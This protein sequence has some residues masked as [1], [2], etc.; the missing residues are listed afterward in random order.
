MSHTADFLLELGCEELPAR[1]VQE[2]ARML[3]D[4]LAGE[5]EKAGLDFDPGASRRLA[6]PRRLTVFF[7]GLADRQ[8]DRQLDRK[9][10]AVSAAFDTDG[11]P[12]RAAEGFA[13][14]VGLPV[15][16]LERLKNEQG[17]WLFARIDEPGKPL[18]DLLPEMLE[19]IIKTM[20][21]ARS[22][23]WGNRSERFLRPVRWLV[24]L[25]GDHVL[26]LETM[27]LTATAETRGHRVHAPGP[28][29]LKSAGDYE[30][31]LEQ[32]YVIADPARR[33]QRIAEQV[34]AAA[35]QAGLA[36][37]PDADLLSEVSNLVEWPRPVL[38]EFDA[39]FLTVPPEALIASMQQHQKTFP[40]FD[41]QGNLANRFVAIANIEST[42]P[43]AMRA[44]FERVIRPRLSDAKFFWDQDRRTP[45]AD[46]GSRLADVRFQEKMGSVG[47]KVQRV[48]SLSEAMA[49]FLNPSLSDTI[50][51]A[52]HLSKCDLLTEMVGEF[53]E[54][55][56]TMGKYYALESGEDEA[57][58]TAI[59]S[60]YRPRFA[61]DDLPDDE[62]KIG[63]ILALADRADTLVGIFA[64]GRKPKGGKDPFALRRAALGVVR[65]LVEKRFELT[66]DDLLHF[67]SKQLSSELA[68]NDATL[69]A[70]RTFILD[71]LRSYAQSQNIDTNT[72]YAVNAVFDPEF[73][74]LADFM[75]R[76]HAVQAFADNPEVASLI[77]ANKRIKNILEQAG[78]ATFNPGDEDAVQDPA[79]KQLLTGLNNADHETSP[80]PNWSEQ[81]YRKALNTLAVLRDPVDTFFD[82]VMVMVDDEDL[83]HAR[84]ALLTRLREVFTRI[85]DVA[86]LGR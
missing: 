4:G 21:G 49:E 68:V 58:A 37:H 8:P 22:M 27:G 42:D 30:T 38:G 41:D 26:P 36:A 76:A 11:N 15:E 29:R 80:G 83:R 74:T 56:G 25:H 34:Q 75:D 23:K 59:E 57:V 53:P 52:A 6:T 69:G 82:Q 81:D 7:S 54:L 65:I 2:Q 18:A 33:R 1:Q 3:F 50:S 19:D 66:L 28:H 62:D 67:T 40:L 46:Y 32:A 39:E 16:K 35:Q 55:Q 77:A 86:L 20:A 44:G 14:S 71:R 73:H 9:G 43:D 45:L 78:T 31:V 61:D 51:R 48:T 72:F 10:P 47:D 12:T 64:A 63:Q 84:L 79:E 85:A 5:F 70:V 17:E 13:R 24:A 60:H